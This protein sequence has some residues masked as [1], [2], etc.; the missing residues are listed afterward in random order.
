MKSLQIA[1]IA[2][3][4][5]SAG[6]SAEPMSV[7]SQIQNICS[8]AYKERAAQEDFKIKT[9]ILNA[10]DLTPFNENVLRAYKTALVKNP[11]IK[12]AQTTETKNED[13]CEPNV[14]K[15]YDLLYPGKR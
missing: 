12:E 6:A 2:G 15:E 14:E 9:G 11:K 4:A 8:A 3:I 5:F 13:L 10:T 1:I 7:N